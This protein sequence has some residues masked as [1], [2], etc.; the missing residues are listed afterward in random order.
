MAISR[1]DMFGYAGSSHQP[2]GHVLTAEE[3]YGA[4]GFGAL[5]SESLAAEEAY[6]ALTSSTLFAEEE[7]GLDDDDDDD[8]GL[9]DDDDDDYGLDDD[10]DDD[11]DE[12]GGGYAWYGDDDEDDDEFGALD[13]ESLYAEE[14]YGED[15]DE[16]DFG[17]DEFGAEVSDELDA[18]D[19]ELDQEIFGAWYGAAGGTL[20]APSGAEQA[21]GALAD[22]VNI[23]A[24]LPSFA[25][26]SGAEPGWIE[27]GVEKLQN[28]VETDDSEELATY[29]MQQPGFANWNSLSEAQQAQL[30]KQAVTA[31]AIPGLELNWD[32][33]FRQA[34]SQNP[35]ILGL[36]W[37]DL[38][39]APSAIWG[40]ITSDYPNSMFAVLQ[41]IP[42]VGAA[43]QGL[44]KTVGVQRPDQLF[45]ALAIRY[46]I[47]GLVYPDIYSWIAQSVTRQGQSAVAAI[48]AVNRPAVQDVAPLPP[49][50]P[51]PQTMAEP[52]TGLP[53]PP[54]ILAVGFGLSAAGAVLGIFK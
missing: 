19:A 31:A 37:A 35:G 1:T 54:V 23:G 53:S 5:D 8:Y 12:F 41:E 43:L 6:G 2:Q 33:P 47:L 49:M 14:A 3:G 4:H 30:V 40:L 11:D 52:T 10:D 32:E 34:F 9:D 46:Y 29:L 18:L 17:L 24:F 38:A 26:S 51:P 21:V 20:A 13:S 42:G 7:Y 44:A 16:E 50:M 27:W 28:F 39:I 48:D 22:A 25:Q 15:E 36:G 45:N